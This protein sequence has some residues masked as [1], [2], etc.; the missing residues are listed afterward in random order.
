MSTLSLLIS[1]QE[2]QQIVKRATADLVAHLISE[3][4]D[5][6]GYISPAQAAGM[7]DI[8]ANTLAG[9][10]RSELPRYEIV[11]GKVIRYKLTEVLTYIKKTRQ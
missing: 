8:S 9:I 4:K 11:K 2:R 3:H 7:L 5:A 1:E 10:P 6:G